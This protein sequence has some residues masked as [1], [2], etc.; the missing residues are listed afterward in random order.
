M[1]AFDQRLE[2]RPDDRRVH[3][4]RAGERG[5]PAIR[6]GDDPLAADDAVS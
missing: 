3:F 5:E 6:T 1:G 4:V 2:L